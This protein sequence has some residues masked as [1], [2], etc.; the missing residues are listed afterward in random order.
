MSTYLVAFVVSK[1]GHETSPATGNNVEFRTWAR[2]SALDQI[3]YA[4]DIG[5]KILEYFET[6]FS[7]AYPLPKQVRVV[8]RNMCAIQ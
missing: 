3:A 5:P 4:K 1:F 7:A 2:N 6:Y 8:L